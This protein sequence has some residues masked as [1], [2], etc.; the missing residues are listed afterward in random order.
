MRALQVFLD[1][2]VDQP[3]IASPDGIMRA[4]FPYSAEVDTDL[5]H[6]RGQ[7]VWREYLRALESWRRSGCR[8][9]ASYEARPAD[10]GR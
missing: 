5:S 3:D 9:E 1:D 2:V 7:A 6:D 8:A 10:P 4:P